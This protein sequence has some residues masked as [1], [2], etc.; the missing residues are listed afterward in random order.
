MRLP[1]SFTA[2]VVS[3]R[4]RGRKIGAPTMNLALADVDPSLQEGVYACF[5]VIDGTR[6][7]AAMHFGPRPAFQD[8]ATCE[9][10]LLDGVPA[11]VPPY[12]L[13]E[14]IARLR[15]V[16]DFPSTE[17]LMGQIARDIAEARAILNG[18]G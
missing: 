2:G 14:V 11:D 1:L 15:E 8:S 17:A 3:G 12:L 5:T 10:H 7:E 13:V 6:Y 16:R 4:G 9:I 18:H